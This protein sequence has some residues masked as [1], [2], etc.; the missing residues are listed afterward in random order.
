MCRPTYW[1]NTGRIPCRRYRKCCHEMQSI[2]DRINKFQCRHWER[3]ILDCYSQLFQIIQKLPL[4]TCQI[5]GKTSFNSKDSL[6]IIKTNRFLHRL[7]RRSAAGLMETSSDSVVSNS[8]VTSGMKIDATVSSNL[9]AAGDMMM[10]ARWPVNVQRTGKQLHL[11]VLPI[12]F[13]SASWINSK[14]KKC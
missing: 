6:R 14:R 3:D 2:P 4:M 7:S 10:N 13:T 5:K 9:I 11:K 1:R 12:A 8:A